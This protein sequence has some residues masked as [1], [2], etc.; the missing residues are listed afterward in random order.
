[1]GAQLLK[2]SNS[3][4]LNFPNK[5]DYERDI[6]TE[7]ENAN[8]SVNVMETYAGVL[9]KVQLYMNGHFPAKNHVA[10]QEFHISTPQQANANTKEA[11]EVIYLDNTR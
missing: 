6:Q 5:Q 10:N 1:M 7:M 2:I 9:K 8:Q 11:K 4:G 3:S